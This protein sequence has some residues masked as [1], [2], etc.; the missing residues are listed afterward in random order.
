MS[1]L[2]TSPLNLTPATLTRRVQTLKCRFT[3]WSAPCHRRPAWQLTR[4]WHLEQAGY[5][6]GRRFLE[7]ME[8]Q[9]WDSVDGQLRFTGGP[10]PSTTIGTSDLVRPGKPVRGRGPHPRF[11]PGVSYDSPIVEADP[12]DASDS[13]EYELSGRFVRPL[14]P[15]ELPVSVLEAVQQKKR[16]RRGR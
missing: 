11:G 16:S 8:R 1:T 2:L 14:P 13:W 12:L 3:I 4:C 6:A 10:F 7:D 5:E 15:L 9:G